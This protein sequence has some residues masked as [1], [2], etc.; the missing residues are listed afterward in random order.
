M[1]S[2]Y[3]M[4]RKFGEDAK[5]H[6]LTIVNEDDAFE[7]ARD[8]FM[9]IKNSQI[10]EYRTVQLVQVDED[11]NGW[12]GVLYQLEFVSKG[13]KV[14]YFPV[15]DFE[16]SFFGSE[17]PCCVDACEMIRLFI[18]WVDYWHDGSV[19]NYIESMTVADEKQIEQFGVYNS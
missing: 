6:R 3:V 12:L 18:E 11:E 16:E 8:Y 10:P 13:E 15:S 1:K 19:R 2:Y 5:M 14:Y 4:S 7:Q 9:G 17:N